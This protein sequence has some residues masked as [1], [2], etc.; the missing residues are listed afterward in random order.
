ME[1]L[2]PA[3]YP[4]PVRASAYMDAYT[5]DDHAVL[6][7]LPGWEH[8]IVASGFSGHGFKMSPAIGKIISELFIDG[9]TESNISHLEPGRIL[10]EAK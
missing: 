9:K 7:E 10:K 3:L 4:D 8:V 5:P 1:A 2:L 6:G